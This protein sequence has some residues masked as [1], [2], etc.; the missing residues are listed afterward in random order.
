MAYAFWRAWILVIYSSPLWANFSNT[1]DSVAWVSMY[2]W[3]TVA[4]IVTIVLMAVFYKQGNRIISSSW[5]NLLAGVL[6]AVGV[7]FEYLSLFIFESSDAPLFIFGAL[8]TGIGTAQVALFSGNLYVRFTSSQAYSKI[9]LS[10]TWAGLI[11]FFA[12]GTF[13]EAT[14]VIAAILPLLGM[15]IAA[16]ERYRIEKYNP[17]FSLSFVD[18]ADAAAPEGKS[19]G[20]AKAAHDTKAA[21]DAKA[22]AAKASS[23]ASVK[24]SAAK[25]SSGANSDAPAA[26][27]SSRAQGFGV[28]VRFLIVIILLAFA[29]SFT[30]NIGSAAS[31]TTTVSDSMI[32]GI[33]AVIAVSFISSCLIT[34]SD[35]FDFYMLYYPLVLLLAFSVVMAFSNVDGSVFAIACVC[36]SYNFVS[37]LLTCVLIFAAKGDQWDSTW[38][39]GLGRAAYAFGSLVGIMIG[40]S[41]PAKGLLAGENALTFGLVLAFLVAVLAVFMFRESDAYKLTHKG[42]ATQVFMVSDDDAELFTGSAAPLSSVDTFAITYKLT[43]R[44]T[45]VF[46]LLVQGFDTRNIST[47]L[48]VSENTTK[49]HIHNIYAKL[50]VK[51]RQGFLEKTQH[52]RNF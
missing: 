4:F 37:M 36:F 40:L 26:Q 7:G 41:A 43:G 30:K 25:A 2:I 49:T 42:K 32:L 13:R 27:K 17:G 23:G 34:L 3:S 48:Y 10:E 11:F 12:I 22:P 28:F 9:L 8:L 14:L 20:D 1:S 31:V 5:L 44:E 51:N 39:F 47:K 33:T 38:V 29:A 24:A 18:M 6:V 52:L 50:G 35:K 16:L 46:A 15:G 45:E 21:H 19:T